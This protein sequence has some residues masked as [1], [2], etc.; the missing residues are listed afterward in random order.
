MPSS[1]TQTI[2]LTVTST[3]LYTP[4]AHTPKASLFRTPVPEV[5]VASFDPYTP[6]ADPVISVLAESTP[7]KSNSGPT[8]AP[9]F[10][11]T[12]APASSSALS[13][14]IAGVVLG[15]VAVVGIFI[16]LAL[17][18]HR[19]RKA[20]THKDTEAAKLEDRLNEK[21]ARAQYLGQKR[22]SAHHTM[23]RKGRFE[24]LRAKM[25]AKKDE[26]IVEEH[27]AAVVGEEA[28]EMPQVQYD[29]ARRPSGLTMY[30][31]TP[32]SAKSKEGVGADVGRVL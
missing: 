26:A 24:K 17:Y 12:N 6:P 20:S 25:A 29:Q 19:R 21:I 27:G 18:L 3:V 13:S 31:P 28:V 14:A 15:S 23:A 9:S 4:A 11:L 10:S 32:K 1:A 8:P 2:H 7:I 16:V 30:P 22:W 5:T